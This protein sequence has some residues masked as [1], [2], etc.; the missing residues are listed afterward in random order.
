MRM[1]L[2]AVVGAVDDVESFHDTALL[3]I[4][5]DRRAYLGFVW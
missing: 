4:E 2:V 3:D 5:L 1:E